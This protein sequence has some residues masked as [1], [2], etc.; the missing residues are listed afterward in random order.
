MKTKA[1]VID[2]GAVVRFTAA[3]FLLAAIIMPLNALWSKG[4][5]EVASGNVREIKSTV[6]F[7]KIVQTAGNKI[8]IVDLYAVWCAPCRMLA[9]TLKK[10]AGAH[11][12]RAI[13]LKVNVDKYRSLAARYRVRRI[14]HVVF[15]KK[16]K[17]VT[18]LTGLYPEKSYTQVIDKYGPKKKSKNRRPKN[19]RK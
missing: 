5:P 11:K 6:E 2:H 1:I 12:G 18:A 8:V 15:L 9:P 3:F 19:K 17:V 14:P 10:I 13:V 7:D 4:K 16:G